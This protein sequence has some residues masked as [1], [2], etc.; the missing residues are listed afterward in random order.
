MP[1][2]LHTQGQHGL[3]YPFAVLDEH[4]Q[5]LSSHHEAGLWQLWGENIAAGSELL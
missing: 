4:S 5:S 1:G 3:D 2:F